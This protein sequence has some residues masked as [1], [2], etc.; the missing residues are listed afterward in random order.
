MKMTI[1]L[2]LFL[3]TTC[4][5]AFSSVERPFYL[6]LEAGPVWNTYNSIA[7]PNDG[8]ATKFSLTDTVNIESKIA[9]RVRLGYRIA[10]RHSVSVL[11]APLSLKGSGVLSSNIDFNEARFLESTSIDAVYKFNSYRLTYAYTWVDRPQLKFQVGFTA[12]IRDAKISISDAVTSSVKKNTGFVPLLHFGLL[13]L[14]TE[15]LSFQTDL[16]AMIAPQGRAEDLSLGFLW[17]AYPF[18]S[19]KLGYRVVEGGADVTE[20]YNFA[21]LQYLTTGLIIEL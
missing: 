21:C 6:D 19:F 14:I 18:L 11:Y 3:L 5:T 20:V 1:G 15:R 12:K 8:T 4:S 13:W 7:I 17:R 10:E 2:L 9:F 16:D